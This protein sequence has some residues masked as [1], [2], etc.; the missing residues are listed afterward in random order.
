MGRDRDL[1]TTSIGL[2]WAHV[3]QS[4]G[5][6]RCR[7]CDSHRPTLYIDVV[8]PQRCWLTKAKPA[9]RGHLNQA[10]P[11][12]AHCIGEGIQLLH[13]DHRSVR[14]WLFP[15]STPNRAWISGYQPILCGRLHDRPQESVALGR[16]WATW[17]VRAAEMTK[18]P[19]HSTRLQ[20]T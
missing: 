6:N 18:P 8:L 2:R 7:L 20:V 19:A 17:P 11:A 4:P 12:V 9:P 3:A 10:T 16:G 14:R 13:R 1:S 5:K 15:S